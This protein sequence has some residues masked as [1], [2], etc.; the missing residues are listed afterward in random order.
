MAAE[1]QRPVVVLA[2]FSHGHQSL[3]VLVGL[4]RVDV[5]QGAAVARVSV[6]CCEVD[7]D[8]QRQQPIRDQNQAE[9]PH[10]SRRDVTVCLLVPLQRHCKE[11]GMST[12]N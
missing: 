1:L 4:V 7:G 6:G 9:K 3:Q 8:L 12:F 2:D 11:A 10:R 5:V